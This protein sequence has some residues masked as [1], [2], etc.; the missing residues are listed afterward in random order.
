MIL[1][2]YILYIVTFLVGFVFAGQDT[3]TCPMHLSYVVEEFGACPLCGMDL[4]SVNR[5]QDNEV[6]AQSPD[7]NSSRMSIVISPETIQNMGI[8]TEKV[9]YSK[10]GIEL[11]SYGRV[12]ENKRLR[13]AISSRVEGWIE[14]LQ[15]TALGDEIKKGDLL[16]T[17]YSPDLISAQQDFFAALVRRN[18]SRILSTAKRLRS[19]GVDD[20][21]IFEIESKQ[22]ELDLVPF[23][24]DVGGIISSL[25]VTKGSYIQ[26]GDEIATIQNY[27]SVWIEVSV[28]EKDL[29]FLSK[30][31][32]ATVTFPNLGNS[33]RVAVVDYIYPT[34]NEISR[35]A[36]V[37]LVLE[38]T[39]GSLRPGAYTDALFETETTMRLSISSE[40]ILKSMKGD[41]V[42]IAMGDGRFHPRKIRTGIQSNERTEVK[43]GLNEWERVVVSG[44]FMIDS[45]SSLRESFRK[46][47]GFPEGLGLDQIQKS[48]RAYDDK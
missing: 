46:M 13:N 6:R 15:I 18:D 3:Y 12:T 20:N 42:I 38:N 31:S 41:F 33:V 36:T 43:N 45:E 35:T 40:A 34:I 29:Q 30:K 37:R 17:L 16:Y 1:I 9:A 25:S 11:R 27:S 28:A 21:V 48:S 8:R 47:Q 7:D 14:H 32:T 26:P 24:S 44:Q 5:D 39:D 23:Y 2:K 19:L 22:R 10:F 4:V